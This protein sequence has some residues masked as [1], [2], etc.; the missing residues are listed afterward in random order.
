MKDGR[1]YVSDYCMNHS[2]LEKNFKGEK[3][4]K[5]GI[6]QKI[7]KGAPKELTDEFKKHLKKTKLEVTKNINGEKKAVCPKCG[8][9]FLI[10]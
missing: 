2:Q 5:D 9:G 6:I 7:L 1:P 10:K 8:M 3:Y 4:K